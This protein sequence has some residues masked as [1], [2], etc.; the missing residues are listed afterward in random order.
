MKEVWKDIK[1]YEG[2]Y[3]VSSIGRVKS[4][5]R[6]II[7]GYGAKRVFKE[8]ILKSNVNEHNGY[9]Y[10]GLHKDGK[11]RSARVHRLVAL[12]FL[13]NDD[14][15]PAVNHKNEIKT[16]NFVENLEWCDAKYNNNY[17]NQKKK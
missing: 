14:N 1:G 9:L 4:L 11:T 15:L 7:I 10:V 5:E 16:D 3:Q 12:A 2:I 6:I 8:K 13:E 17:S